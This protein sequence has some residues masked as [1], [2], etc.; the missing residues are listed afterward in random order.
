MVVENLAKIQ[1]PVILLIVGKEAYYNHVVVV[2]R[3]EIIDF[4]S[5]EKYPLS[6]ANVKNI[7][8]SSNPF[9]RVSRGY[10]IL[11]S[12]KMKHAVGDKSDWGETDL[13]KKFAHLFSKSE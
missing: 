12:K 9:L 10:V 7:C 2:W 13:M 4:E 11:P 6:V 8:G 3:K 1:L 5:R